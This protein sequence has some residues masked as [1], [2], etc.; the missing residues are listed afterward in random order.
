MVE[1]DQIEVINLEISKGMYIR[2]KYGIS[3]IVEFHER[4]NNLSCYY[5]D[6]NI[7]EE[8][9]YLSNCIYGYKYYT[10]QILKAS[11]DIIDLI[12]YMD[13]LEIEGSI[14]IY[15]ENKTVALF[16]PVRCDGFTEFEDGTHCMILNLDYLVNIKDLKIKSVL[17]KEQF[18]A[19]KYVVER[20]G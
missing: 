15:G 4:K 7:M 13:L 5:L 9:K 20:D 2:T 11:F 8:E 14:K 6:K 10:D 16:N 19:M 3:R 18:E 12:E 17:T 1:I